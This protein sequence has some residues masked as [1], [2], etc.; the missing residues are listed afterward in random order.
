M[1]SNDRKLD[2]GVKRSATSSLFYVVASVRGDS[3]QGSGGSALDLSL[4]FRRPRR[5]RWRARWHVGHPDPLV[6]NVDAVSLKVVAPA[7]VAKDRRGWWCLIG[8]RRRIGRSLLIGRWCRIHRVRIVVIRSRVRG[9]Q[10][11]TTNE[12]R[13]EAAAEPTEAL[14]AMEA[15]A[16]CAAME[17][18]AVQ[19]AVLKTAAVESAVRRSP[20]DSGRRWRGER[21]R[22]HCY[23]RENHYPR[24]HVAPP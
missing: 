7:D 8:W 19:S 10:E 24:N 12:H 23:E 4:D 21:K 9:V 13:T 11:C 3:E 2:C 22:Q 16:E 20:A 6:R 5:R 18:G 1:S 17:T 14:A 15:A